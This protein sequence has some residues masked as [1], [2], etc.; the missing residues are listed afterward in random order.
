MSA[1][2]WSPENRFLIE[3]IISRYKEP[4]RNVLG[5]CVMWSYTFMNDYHKPLFQN[6]ECSGRWVCFSSIDESKFTPLSIILIFKQAL[7]LLHSQAITYRLPLY[8]MDAL[9]SSGSEFYDIESHKN[10]HFVLQNRSWLWHLVIAPPHH[11][12]LAA[13]TEWAVWLS[14]PSPTP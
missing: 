2:P 13:P 7:E 4:G 1:F 11:D 9:P 6:R 8:A 5:T 14:F 12:P 10:K 3:E